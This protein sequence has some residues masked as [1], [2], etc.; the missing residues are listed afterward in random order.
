KMVGCAVI[1]VNG[2]DADEVVRATRLAV[3]YQ[4]RFRKDVI[5]DLLCYRQWGH[6]ELGQPP[7]L[8]LP[9]TRSSAPGRAPQT[10]T[11]TS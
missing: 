5:L 4:R 6:N 1:H 2:D 9:C 10:L 3:E 8:T 7:S 11:L